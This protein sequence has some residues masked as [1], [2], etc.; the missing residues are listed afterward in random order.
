[1]GSPRRRSR[2]AAPRTLSRVSGIVPCAFPP[3]VRR[4]R[5]RRLIPWDKAELPPY[6]TIS[7]QRWRARRRTAMTGR[8]LVAVGDLEQRWLTPRPTKNLQ[9]GR[10]RAMRESHRHGHRRESGRR[11]E[12]IAVVA[13]RTVEVAD[14]ARRIVP[15]RVDQHIEPR[16]VHGLERALS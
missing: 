3:F 12:A 4:F 2:P 10:Q 14:Q 5:L 8:L 1:E 6:A 7:R 16:L 13:V 11:R 9:P 15:C